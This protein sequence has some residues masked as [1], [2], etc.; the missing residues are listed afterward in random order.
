[1]PNSWIR[2]LYTVT[3][4]VDESVFRRLSDFKRVGNDWIAKKVYV[5]KCV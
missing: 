5:V 4:G 2:E 3:K 1:M